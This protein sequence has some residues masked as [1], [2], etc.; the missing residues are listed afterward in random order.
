MQTYLE[1]EDL[2]A[3]ARRRGA[4]RLVLSDR[5]DLPRAIGVAHCYNGDLLEAG[6]QIYETHR[7][8][9][10]AKTIVVD[11]ARSII[12]SSY[13]D[14]CRVR[15]NDQVDAGVFGVATAAALEPVFDDEAKSA[16]R[17][18]PSGWACRPVGS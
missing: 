6:V 4:V 3:A 14:A 7:V 1:R 5:S 16:D 10:H 13:F 15:L 11:G 12:G 8:A 17:I 2:A 9:L 18:D